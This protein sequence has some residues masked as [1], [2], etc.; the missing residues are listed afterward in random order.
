MAAAAREQ[1]LITRFGTP[2]RAPAPSR[3]RSAN[4]LVF[5]S[6]H[7]TR[8]VRSY[9]LLQDLRTP[10]CPQQ[11]GMLERV[12]RTLKEQCV[13]RHRFES[14]QY[15]THVVGDWIL[16]YNQRRPHQ[17]RGTKTPAEACALAARPV[18]KQLGHY[19]HAA[20]MTQCSRDSHV[21]GLSRWPDH[22][23]FGRPSSCA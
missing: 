21:A 8:L 12:V 19:T 1:A 14:Q 4:G 17:A 15:P 20:C 10:H 6:R 16:F 13:L 22:R 11:S 7:Y 9:G 5:T 2:G 23:Y 3:L 18:Q